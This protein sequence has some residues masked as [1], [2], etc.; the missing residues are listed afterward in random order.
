MLVIEVDGISHTWEETIDKDKVKEER[1]KEAG[2]H[3]LRFEDESVLK[4]M[5][6]VIEEIDLKIEEIERTSSVQPAKRRKRGSL[7]QPAQEG[8]RFQPQS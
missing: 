3:I 6:W 1:L 2:F 5:N 4:H 7:P 8:D